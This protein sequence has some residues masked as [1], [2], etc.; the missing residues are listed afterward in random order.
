MSKD[1]RIKF[2]LDAGSVYIQIEDLNECCFEVWES[3]DGSTSSLVKVKIP[4]KDWKKMVKKWNLS[5]KKT[6]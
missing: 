3:T 1:T 4:V 6:K 5:K 2:E